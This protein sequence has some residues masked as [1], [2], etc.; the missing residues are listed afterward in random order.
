MK[1]RPILQMSCPLC[2][3]DVFLKLTR[4]KRGKMGFSIYCQVCNSRIFSTHGILVLLEE[5]EQVGDVCW[6]QTSPKELLE[7]R[8]VE[9]KSV[10]KKLY[11]KI[12]I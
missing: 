9:F 6:L 3:S 7:L 4:S 8:A 5:Q 10:L 11:E 2:K 12:C 1:T